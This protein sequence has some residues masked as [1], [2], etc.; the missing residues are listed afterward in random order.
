MSAE[1]KVLIGGP[2]HGETHVVGVGVRAPMRGYG[3]KYECGHET[4]AIGWYDSDGV[5]EHPE[6]DVVELGHCADCWKGDR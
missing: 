1:Q 6:R 3:W 5:W 2:Y 4:F